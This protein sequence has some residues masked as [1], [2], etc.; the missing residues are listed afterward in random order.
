MATS[1]FISKEPI[2]QIDMTLSCI[3]SGARTIKI[4]VGA[5]MDSCANDESGAFADAVRQ[6]ASN[7]GYM[8]DE[9]LRRLGSPGCV[10]GAEEWILPPSLRC[11]EQQ[12]EEVV[13][14]G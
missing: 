14:H 3:A 6:V 7:I 12:I 4:L 13:H 2:E 9:G 11:A 8:A 5:M 10:G 1:N